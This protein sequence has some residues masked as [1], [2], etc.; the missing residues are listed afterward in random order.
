MANFG[1]VEG[2]GKFVCKINNIPLVPGTY[3]INAR[4]INGGEVLDYMQN[5]IPIDVLDG[6]FFG[7]GSS[8][9]HSLVYIKH[10]WENQK[11]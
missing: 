7:T 1:I 11:I 10:N 3:F 2:K 9:R 4:I 6:N 5:I 8:I